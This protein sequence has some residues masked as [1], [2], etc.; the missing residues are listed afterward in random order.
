MFLFRQGLIKDMWGTESLSLSLLYQVSCEK[1]KLS[2]IYIWERGESWHRLSAKASIY[3][4]VVL[5]CVNCVHVF[6][7][8][9]VIYQMRLIGLVVKFSAWIVHVI[10]YASCF[11]RTILYFRCMLSRR[12]LSSSFCVAWWKKT[13]NIWAYDI[14]I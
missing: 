3:A 2:S 9:R 11:I 8:T 14:R 4:T 5:L 7:W 10:Q 13:E 1:E 6:V 12:M